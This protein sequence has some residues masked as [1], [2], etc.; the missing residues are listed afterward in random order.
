MGRRNLNLQLF[1]ILRITFKENFPLR[2]NCLLHCLLRFD[3]SYMIPAFKYIKIWI[4]KVYEFYFV[5]KPI[6]NKSNG[7][8]FATS[9]PKAVPC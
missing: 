4:Y 3:V 2:N 9:S 7:V 5:K 8:G 6:L 1:V